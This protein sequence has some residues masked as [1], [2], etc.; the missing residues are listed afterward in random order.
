MGLADLFRAANYTPP[1]KINSLVAIDHPIPETNG[2]IAVDSLLA[3]MKLHG[4]TFNSGVLAM[5]TERV[6]DTGS[7]PNHAIWNEADNQAIFHHVVHSHASSDGAGNNI[8]WGN[9]LNRASWDAQSVDG[10]DITGFAGHRGD[11]APHD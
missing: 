8:Q 3:R 5:E 11:L 9:Y 7:F 4:W 10:W 2:R 6:Y 1:R